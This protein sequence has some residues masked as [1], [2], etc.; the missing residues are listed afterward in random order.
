MVVYTQARA[1][2]QVHIR[3]ADILGVARLEARIPQ[4]AHIRE[5]AAGNRLP[6]WANTCGHMDRDGTLADKDTGRT[7][8][9]RS[10]QAR[11]EAGG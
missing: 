7:R 9:S 6:H 8:R 3:S 10:A 1:Q 5:V 11:Q 4:A 2:A